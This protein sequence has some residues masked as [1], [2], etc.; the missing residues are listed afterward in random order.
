[1]ANNP[2]P[3]LWC[4]IEDDSNPFEVTPPVAAS[5]SRLKEL[6]WEKGRNGVLRGTDA[7]DLALYKVSSE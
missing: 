3:M 7:K 2:H 5:V 1:M 4:L 6:V